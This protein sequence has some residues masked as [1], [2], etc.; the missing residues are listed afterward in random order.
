M[1]GG[2]RGTLEI[3][4]STYAMQSV[5]PFEAVAGVKRIGYEGLELNCGNDWATAPDRFGDDDRKKLKEAFQSAGFPPP[6]IMNLIH[7]CA[8]GEDVGKKMQSLEET[9]VLA[10]DLCWLDRPSVV[11]TTLGKQAGT[12]EE[13]RDTVVQKLKPYADLA[14]DHNVIIAAEA[15][16][17][18]EMD[19]P[20][21]ARWLVEAMD[22]PNLRLNFDFSHFLLLDTG[23]Q[24]AIDLNAEYSVH[25]H[26]KDGS[27]VDGKVQF[28]LPGDDRLDLVDYLTRV[29]NSVLGVPITVEVSGQIWKGEDYDPWATAEHCFKSLDGAREAVL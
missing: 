18:Q 3:A 1:T 28:A 2:G 14:G 16:V 26:I 4:Y 25:T 5:D 20:E 19:T 29:N 6:V 12:W 10:R 8:E 9:C 23:L 11:T 13:A 7:L 22:H 24:H 21:K 27:M 17:G 15:H